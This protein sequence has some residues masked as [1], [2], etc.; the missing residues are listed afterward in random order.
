MRWEAWLVARVIPKVSC[1]QDTVYVEFWLDA[2]SM[3][4]QTA[5]RLRK[6]LIKD[7]LKSLT[8]SLSCNFINP[9]WP[10]I[11]SN[12]PA[13]AVRKQQIG[14]RKKE[15]QSNIRASQTKKFTP[16][17]TLATRGKIYSLSDQFIFEMIIKRCYDGYTAQTKT[18]KEFR[19]S[20]KHLKET[21]GVKTLVLS[22]MC[23]AF[24]AKPIKTPGKNW[25]VWKWI[26]GWLT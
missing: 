20:G 22:K 3:L 13:L 16:Q 10:A 9:L 7:Y 17:Q 12:F 14:P 19:C 24:E 8:W 4:S 21:L 1:L 11:I 18:Y 6:I 26:I 5:K 23:P 2:V 25:L 15:F